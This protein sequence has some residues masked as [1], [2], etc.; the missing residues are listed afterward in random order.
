MSFAREI[1]IACEFEVSGKV[2]CNLFK[3]GGIAN[4]PWI[5]CASITTGKGACVSHGFWTGG[6][7]G[8]I[9]FGGRSRGDGGKKFAHAETAS[10]QNRNTQK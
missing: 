9:H 1:D 7:F 2:I 4:E 10:V 5:S 3:L 8:V 6:S